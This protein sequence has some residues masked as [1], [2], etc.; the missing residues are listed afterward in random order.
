MF[1]WAG[2]CAPWRPFRLLRRLKPPYHLYG[3]VLF[4]GRRRKPPNPSPGRHGAT[5]WRAKRRHFREDHRVDSVQDSTRAWHASVSRGST[6]LLFSCDGNGCGQLRHRAHGQ[7][8][9]PMA[10][11]DAQ[12]ASE[13]VRLEERYKP[14]LE[15]LS[16]FD[17]D[18]FARAAAMR[19]P[20]GGTSETFPFFSGWLW[21]RYQDGGGVV[22]WKDGGSTSWTTGCA[23]RERATRSTRRAWFVTCPSIASQC[24]RNKLP[25]GNAPT[26]GIRSVPRRRRRPASV[27]RAPAR[28]PIDASKYSAER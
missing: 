26:A 17:Q 15:L 4:D 12:D 7:A 23:T 24:E 2:R 22:N 9:R 10:P 1:R 20:P 11:Y 14:S 19:N 18:A 25:N 27:S 6:P 28:G 5:Q 3:G 13:K 16:T 21:K 8:T